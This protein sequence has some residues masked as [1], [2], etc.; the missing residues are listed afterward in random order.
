MPRSRWQVRSTV[1]R[2]GSIELLDLEDLAAFVAAAGRTDL[3]RWLWL[4]TGRAQAPASRLQRLV[5]S[6][7]TSS[8]S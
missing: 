1:S 7:F 2:F 4:E 5:R 8:A 6:A 3:M